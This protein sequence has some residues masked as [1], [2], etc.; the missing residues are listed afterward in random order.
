MCRDAWLLRTD[1]VGGFVGPGEPLPANPAVTRDLNLVLDE[2]VTWATLE[3]TV[4]G[5]AGPHLEQ[6]RFV[7][8][9]RGKHIPSGKKSY[10]FSMSLRAADRTLTSEEI[11]AVQASVLKACEAELKAALRA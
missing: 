7:D 10:V 5:S 8:Q 3:A 4:R 1:A 6:V 11:D 9:Y 2:S